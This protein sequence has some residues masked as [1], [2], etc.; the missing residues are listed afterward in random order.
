[1]QKKVGMKVVAAKTLGG[2]TV[3]ISTWV[4]GGVEESSNNQERNF[5]LYFTIF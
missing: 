4:G 1:M 5:V 2:A 3:S